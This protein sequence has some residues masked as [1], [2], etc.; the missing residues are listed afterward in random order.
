MKGRESGMPERNVWESFFDPAAALARLS[1]QPGTAV[2]V[3]FGCGYGTF[4]IPAAR[5]ARIVRAFDI[6]PEM[7]AHT[8]DRAR[9]EQLTNVQV[10]VRDFMAD[11]VGLERESADYAMLFNILHVEEP[12]ILLSEAMRILRPG[13][14][15]AVMHWN[16]DPATPRGPSMA[17]RPR[18]EQLAAWC[19]AAGFRANSALIDLPPYHYG[20]VFM[21]PVSP[22]P[23]P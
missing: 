6:D 16:Y 4:T 15:L 14:L 13:G 17:I 1:L 3:E 9:A 10:E 2:A 19:L 21:R 7:A 12:S 11:G 8:V 5:L 20:L 23:S 18:P 22:A